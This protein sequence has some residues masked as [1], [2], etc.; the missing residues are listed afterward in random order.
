MA[1]TDYDIKLARLNP[2]G[3]SAYHCLTLRLYCKYGCTKRIVSTTP[4]ANK[5]TLEHHLHTARKVMGLFGKDVRLYL[6]WHEWE[7]KQEKANDDTKNE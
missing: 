1:P 3:L 7:T 2:W 5:S 4:E 6:Y